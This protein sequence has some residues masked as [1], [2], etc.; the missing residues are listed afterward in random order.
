MADISKMLNLYE[1][2]APC[3]FT[4]AYGC[5]CLFDNKLA[6]PI[7]QRKAQHL[8]NAYLR[9]LKGLVRSGRY[10]TKDDFTVVLL[11]TLVEGDLPMHRP[12]PGARRQV[13]VSY[14]APD[15]FHLAQKSHAKGM[16][17]LLLFRFPPLIKKPTYTV[18]RALWNNLLEPVGHKT[19]HFRPNKPFLCP[20]EESPYLAT[21]Y[22]SNE[23]SP[24]VAMQSLAR[25]YIELMKGQGRVTCPL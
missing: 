4:H 9:G 21:A 20:T 24:E 3:L 17:L 10:D 23:R 16:R 7:S 19:N 1:K 2:P 11:D 14:L 12:R 13:N 22:N 15:C 18:A 25:D 6:S 5:P 8:L